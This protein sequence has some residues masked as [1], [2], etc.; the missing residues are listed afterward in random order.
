MP[1]F[2]LMRSD[3]HA[4]LE[5]FQRS[6]AIISFKP[7]GTILDANDNFCQAL[8][9]KSEE[10]VGKHHRMFVGEGYMRGDGY[11][12]FWKNLSEGKFE[13]G[14]FKRFTKSGDSIW[15]EASYNPVFRGGK[16]VKIV[17][18]AT[19]VTAS[20]K[21]S[22]DSHGK[23]DALSRA[24]AV[25]EFDPSGRILDANQ[26]F[27][28][29]LGYDITEISGQHHRMFCEPAYIA[30][31]EYSRFWERLSAGEYYNDEFKRI[32]KDGKPIYIQATYS[33][34]YDDDGNV[35]K[36]VKFASNV[37]G[38]VVAL[39]QI[40]AGL[41]RLADCNI[42][43]T[44]DEPFV[45]EFDHLRHDFNATLAKFQETLE[46]VLTQTNTLSA[47]CGEL[48]D[49][50]GSIAQRSDQQAAALEQTNQSLAQIT[51]AV[52]ESAERT[53]AARALVDE[54]LSAASKSVQVVTNT[55]DAIGRIEVASDEIGKIT[56][57]IDEI[58]FQTNLLALNAGVEAA[59][60]GEAGKGFAVVAQEVRELA[61]RSAKAAKEIS[62]LIQ[63]SSK[64]VKEGVRL[65]GETGAALA[66]IEVYVHAIDSNVEAVAAAAFQQ[67]SQLQEISSAVGSLDKMTRQNASMVG[68][69]GGTA[70]S[71]ADGAVDL[72]RLVKRFKLN[73]RKRVREPG[74]EAAAGGPAGRLFGKNSLYV[75]HDTGG[76]HGMSAAE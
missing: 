19:D 13:K 37:T 64:E 39:Q 5:S 18:I 16:V 14:Q 63:N 6:Q 3:A 1:A 60:A 76:P 8:G 59:R 43:F 54:A 49:N 68:D 42:R 66:N 35:F 52:S 28:D 2:S 23:L 44:I 73:R 32:R 56:G 57:V 45:P 50:A 51:G 36:V 24:Q 48:S 30:S 21:Q 71:L 41:E 61:L 72:E 65:V 17:K 11:R 26:N 7:D 10:I 15:I 4:V 62:S 74:S 9:Y 29:A 70:G 38:R 12:K 27:L 47:K 20:K 53:T 46:Q 58:A 34:I 33:P 67:K 40:A 75:A 25:I 31:A 69:M 22:L 55:V